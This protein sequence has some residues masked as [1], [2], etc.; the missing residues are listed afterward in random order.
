MRAGAVRLHCVPI[1]GL[2]HVAEEPLRQ[3]P[4]LTQR[5]NIDREESFWLTVTGFVAP[6]S[7]ERGPVRMH[8]Q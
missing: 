8:V 5:Q 4:I 6:L 2:A 3:L 1:R 7:Q